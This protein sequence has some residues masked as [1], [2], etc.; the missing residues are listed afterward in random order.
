MRRFRRTIPAVM[1]ALLVT[2]TA[3][4]GDGVSGDDGA[5]GGDPSD[6]SEIVL[7]F[8]AGALVGGV[9]RETVALGSI[10]VLRIEGQID[11]QVHIHGYDLYVEPD[12]PGRLTFDA[13]IPGRFEIEL[14][15]SGR[16]LVELTVA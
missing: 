11:E 12:G 4:G 14:E 2:A 15:Q 7:E 16:L 9:R 1:M 13:L 3:C 10:V 6:A 8:D 5:G